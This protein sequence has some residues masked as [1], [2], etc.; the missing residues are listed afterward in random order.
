VGAFSDRIEVDR[1]CALAK[2]DTIRRNEYNLY[3]PKYVDT[4]IPEK[5]IKLDAVAAKL[6]E[7]ET[8]AR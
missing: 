6:S 3:I 7:I 4:S 2:P 5:Q 8:K 1:F